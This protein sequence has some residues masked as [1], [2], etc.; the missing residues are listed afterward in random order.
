MP[1]ER[2]L[3]DAV[4]WGIN[5][6]LRPFAKFTD[7]NGVECR[8]IIASSKGKDFDVQVHVQKR[9]QDVDYSRCVARVR[10]VTNEN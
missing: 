2:N 7:H 10:I 5:H 9:G 1:P 6:A 8:A 3:S 4:R